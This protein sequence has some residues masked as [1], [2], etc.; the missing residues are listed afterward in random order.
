MI[1]LS[2]AATCTDLMQISV[3]IEGL[4]RYEEFDS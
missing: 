1:F 4:S 3:G 2:D